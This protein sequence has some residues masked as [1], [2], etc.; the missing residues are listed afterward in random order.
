MEISIYLLS[1]PWGSKGVP[2]LRPPR[3]FGGS[4]EPNQDHSDAS[5]TSSTLPVGK[6]RFTTGRRGKKP[7]MW[8]QIQQDGDAWGLKLSEAFVGS[9]IYLLCLE[10]WP[11][12]ISAAQGTWLEDTIHRFW[13]GNQ[14]RCIWLQDKNLSGTAFSNSLLPSPA[15]LPA[16]APA[17]VLILSLFP[18]KKVSPVH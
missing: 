18:L 14:H 12:S 7:Q 15:D 6:V 10:R 5:Y 1:P 8:V 3:G 9:W 13:A 17:S 11:Y 4:R 2:H 16:L